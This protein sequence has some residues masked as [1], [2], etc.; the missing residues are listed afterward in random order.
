MTREDKHAIRQRRLDLREE[1]LSR[2]ERFR[3][4]ERNINPCTFKV[5]D[6]TLSC[7]QKLASA[8]RNVRERDLSVLLYT[9]AKGSHS[10]K[11]AQQKSQPYPPDTEGERER[12]R[13]EER[14]ERCVLLKIT[15]CST[16]AGVYLPALA[17]AD[18]EN[19]ASLSHC[20]TPTPQ[21]S[22]LQAG[23]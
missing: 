10:I 15:S 13:E 6:A 12:R 23:P 14:K 1:F 7:V 2:G 19:L 8:D 9:Q 21:F 17:L 18:L 20:R 3:D 5:P 22:A 11:L 16:D 4:Y